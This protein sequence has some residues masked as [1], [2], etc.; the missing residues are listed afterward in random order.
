MKVLQ[1]P[2]EKPVAKSSSKSNWPISNREFF[3]IQKYI[4]YA[5]NHLTILFN[6]VKLVF[7]F[8]HFWRYSKDLNPLSSCKDNIK[9]ILCLLWIYYFVG[10]RLCRNCGSLYGN[11][12]WIVC[13]QKPHQWPNLFKI[14]QKNILL[15]T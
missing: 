9:F 6:K 15:Q 12:V 2:R 1:Y 3:L 4:F 8:P 14:I 11:F 13:V 5:I 7:I 10:K